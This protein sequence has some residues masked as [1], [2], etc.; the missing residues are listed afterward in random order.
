MAALAIGLWALL[1]PR[2]KERASAAERGLA[3]IPVSAAV[4][5][6][7]SINVYF[8][9]LGSVTPLATITVKTRID[10]QL[11]SVNYREGE[12]VHKGQQL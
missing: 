6:S 12:T 10:G 11:M 2:S 5:E 7:G 9:G 8:T 3:P 1:H 4:A